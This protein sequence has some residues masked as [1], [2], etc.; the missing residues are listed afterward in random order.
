MTI[1][2]DRVPVN[3]DEAVKILIDGLDMEDVA[4]I[5][6]PRFNSSQLHFG[7]GMY[8]R[9]NWSLWEK[10]TILVK[11]FKDNYGV[12]HAD[13][14]SGI[15]LEC[16]ANDIRGESRR[17]KQLAESFIEHWKKVDK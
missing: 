14:I 16:M 6:R 11:W 2:P 13:D 3:L 4:E 5:R 10:D 7:L 17:D 8:L 12:E 9:N 1:D 15:I